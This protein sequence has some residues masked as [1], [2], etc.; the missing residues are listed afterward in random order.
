VKESE[1]DTMAKNTT[2]IKGFGKADQPAFES[3]K[4]ALQV[5][6]KTSSAIE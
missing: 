2:G 6:R 5:F 4:P 1:L 3:A